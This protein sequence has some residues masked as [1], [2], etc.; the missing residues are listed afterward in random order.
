MFHYYLEKGYPLRE[1]S[2]LTTLEKTFLIASMELT[3]E[4]QEKAYGK[5]K[6]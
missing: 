5:Q 1:L 2:C 6:H 3:I 4:A